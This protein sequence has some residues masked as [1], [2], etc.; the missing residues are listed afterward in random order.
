LTGRLENF[1]FINYASEN[2]SCEGARAKKIN[3]DG[4]ADFASSNR[5]KFLLL[6]PKSN[7]TKKVK[8]IKDNLQMHSIIALV[9]VIEI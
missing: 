8:Y 5:E 6:V 2:E 1:P 9:R 3:I 7:G 4:H